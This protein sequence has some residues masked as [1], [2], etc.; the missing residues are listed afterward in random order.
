MDESSPI[1]TQD[2]LGSVDATIAQIE[3]RPS[4][5]ERYIPTRYPFTYGWDYVRCHSSDFGWD[6]MPSRSEVSGW[7][8]RQLLG[9]DDDATDERVQEVAETLADAYLRENGICAP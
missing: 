9:V 5:P 2:F 7:V 1:Q 3:G 4:N 8:R 6:T